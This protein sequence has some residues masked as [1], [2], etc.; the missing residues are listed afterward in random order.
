MIEREKPDAV[1]AIMPHT[2][3]MTCR[4]TLSN[5][6]CH[7]FVEKPPAITTEQTRQL[8]LL[9]EKHSVLTGVTF[10]RRF[11]PLIRRGKQQC[12]KR[13]IAYGTR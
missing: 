13:G 8:A 7:L 3:C 6:A 4:P 1:Y 2:T 11:S 12:E 9:A 10:Q 5:A